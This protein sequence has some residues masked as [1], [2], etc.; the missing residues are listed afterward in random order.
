MEAPKRLTREVDVYEN[1]LVF[2]ATTSG[3]VFV[4]SIATDVEEDDFEC[5]NDLFLFCL[6]IRP[7]IIIY[8]CML[9]LNVFYIF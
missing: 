8:I 7:Y 2:E 9:N 1:P 3:D 4:P 5:L 6:F